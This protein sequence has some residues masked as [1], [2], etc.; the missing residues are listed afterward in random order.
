M[1]HRRSTGPHAAQAKPSRASPRRPS[2]RLFHDALIPGRKMPDRK[3]NLSI[4]KLPPLLD[5]WREAALRR[6]VD[7]FAGFA[8]SGLEGQRKCLRLPL[9]GNPVC[10]ITGTNKHV[11]T[12]KLVNADGN[13]HLIVIPKHAQS[14]GPLLSPLSTGETRPQTRRRG[15]RTDAA[16]LTVATG[17]T[18]KVARLPCLGLMARG[19]RP[20]VC[21][22]RSSRLWWITI[23]SSPLAARNIQKL[24]RYART[25]AFGRSLA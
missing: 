2:E 5:Y 10:Q 17:P 22:S 24:K 25:N 1:R 4:R 13:Q 16:S 21:R 15:Q 12:P 18:C 9:A 11:G 8:T 19:K 3:F 23:R 6:L 7:N 20:T 14:R